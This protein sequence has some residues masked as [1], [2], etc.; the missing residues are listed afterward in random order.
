LMVVGYWKRG[1]RRWPIKEG[2]GERAQPLSSRPWCRGGR[3]LG[4]ARRRVEDGNVAR[5]A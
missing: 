4:A 5:P 3:Q 2:D 1:R